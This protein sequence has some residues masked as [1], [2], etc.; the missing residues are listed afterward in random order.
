MEAPLTDAEVRSWEDDGFVV[1]QSFAD[2]DTLASLRDAYADILDADAQGDRMLGGI[3]RQIMVPSAAHPTFNKNP[4]IKLGKEVV[5]Q[6]SGATEIVRVFDMLIYKPAGHPHETP[7]HQDM[8][9]TQMPYAPAGTVPA[10]GLVQFWVPL[11][12]VDEDNGCMQFIPGQHEKPMLPHYV[13]GGDPRTTGDSSPSTT[14][15][16]TSIFQHAWSQRCQRVA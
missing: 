12:D 11:D 15:R 7:W 13:A 2:E 9:Y 1:K 14:L 4:L 16:N 10:K 8:S 6:L 5:G 3:T